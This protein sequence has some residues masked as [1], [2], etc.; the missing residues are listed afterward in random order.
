MSSSKPNVQIQQ[1]QQAASTSVDR[2]KN[3]SDSTQVT[4]M[5]FLTMFIIII[6]FLYYFYYNG[7]GNI[8]GISI[9]IIITV[10]LSI[11]GQALMDR[12]GALA[13]GVL[14]ALIGIGIFVRM[15]KGKNK[16]NCDSMDVIYGEKNVDITNTIETGYSLRD[17]YIKTAYNCCSGGDY[18]NDYVSLCALNNLL[19][20]G[21]R[22]LDFEIYSVNDEPV[23]ATSTVDNY[24]VK[25]TFN[26]VKF[27]D[28]MNTI[29]NNAFTDISPNSGDPI[30]LHLRIKSE[31]KNIYKKMA[32]IFQNN[33]NYFLGPAYSNEMKDK[34]DNIHN[35][36]KTK[37]SALCKSSGQNAKIAV[38][39]DK[40]N[41]TCLC[42]G[43][44]CEDCDNF[45]E[46][47]NMTSNS[48]FMQV[49]R[50]DDIQ[51]TQTPDELINYNRT[52]V[53]IGIPNKGPSPENPSSLI[54]REMGCQMLA[55]RYQMV[56]TNIEENDAFFNEAGHAFVLKPPNLREIITILPPP[57]EQKP[58][59]FYDSREVKSEFYSLP[60]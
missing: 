9:I 18:R 60:V 10:M 20:Q 44:E 7:A 55:M 23:V 40:S 58:E 29:I 24:C 59:L 16:R 38:I 21:V 43:A 45:Y 51:F 47:V 1:I 17:Y 35:F 57:P 28:V 50:Y 11:V 42:T 33:N 13:G 4:L 12:A 22:G 41:P 2:L 36:G 31:N 34:N 37:L 52:R 32:Q 27:S 3:M 54:M 30:I 6:A 8:G 53:T 46:Y 56:D 14:G 25:E 26:Y 39:V 15:S 48:T 49:L 19:K 5:T